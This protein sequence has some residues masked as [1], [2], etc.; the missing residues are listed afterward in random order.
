MSLGE[1]IKKLREENHYTQQ[2]LA[3]KLYVSRQTVCRWENGS[4]CP[5]LIMAK[6]LAMELGAGLDELISDEDVEGTAADAYGLWTAEK[7]SERRR[8][9]E[10]QKRILF[11]IE[12]VSSFFLVIQLFL[13][14]LDVRMPLWGTVVGFAVFASTYACNCVIS[15]KLGET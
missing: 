14:Y 4:R 11:V 8:W 12:S 6:K 5:D 1:N 13:I 3:D 9:R 15:K 10:L 7:L 2:Q